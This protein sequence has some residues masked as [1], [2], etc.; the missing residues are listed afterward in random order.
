MSTGTEYVCIDNTAG[1]NVWVAQAGI[2]AMPTAYDEFYDYVLD[3]LPTPT[4]GP[5]TYSGTPI[6]TGLTADVNDAIFLAKLNMSS[7]VSDHGFIGSNYGASN[8]QH[9]GCRLTSN[10]YGYQ[11]DG[12]AYRSIQLVPPDGFA[13]RVGVDL[14]WLMYFNIRAGTF[15]VWENGVYIG[16]AFCD[17]HLCNP[18]STM[19]IGKDGN[20]GTAANFPGTITDACIWE[21]VYLSD[22]FSALRD[23]S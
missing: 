18:T 13:S 5:A 19:W 6:D 23:Y 20:A 9:Y 8:Y 21:N 11:D 15:E 4:Y 10:W 2:Q 7:A 17:R 16:R 22:Y 12:S 3:A 14:C 1:A